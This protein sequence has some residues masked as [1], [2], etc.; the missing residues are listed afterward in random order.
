MK[1]FSSTQLTVLL[2]AA[3]LCLAVPATTVAAGITKV[4]VSDSKGKT[5][6]VKSGR[7]QV[8]AAIDPVPQ[9]LR[10]TVEGTV[11]TQSVAPADLYVSSRVNF[12]G[13][14]ACLKVAQAPASQGLVITHVTLSFLTVDPSGV[15]PT[16]VSV[17]TTSNCGG[18]QVGIVHPTT[19]GLVDIDVTPG[20]ALAP[21]QG[22][23]VLKDGVTNSF[24]ATPHGYLVPAGAVPATT[25]VAEPG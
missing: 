10:T 16:A 6:K 11:A 18:G 4:Q 24:Y 8:D 15:N 2:V 19:K 12:G 17:H 14:L 21:G 9:P 3:M 23:Y 7:L 25:T 20:V 22:L 5:A 13:G 1:L